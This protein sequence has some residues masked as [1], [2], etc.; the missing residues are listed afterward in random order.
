MRWV[1][2]TPGITLKSYTF[3][4]LL[5]LSK[6]NGKKKKKLINAN[7]LIKISFIIP[8]LWHFILISKP[9]KI[10]MFLS[11]SSNTLPPPQPGHYHVFFCPKIVRSNILRVQPIYP[12][13]KFFLSHSWGQTSCWE[14]RTK[15]K[16][17]QHPQ[18]KTIKKNPDQKMT[19]RT[20]TKPRKNNAFLYSSL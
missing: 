13:T 20:S 18:N 8:N 19:P 12:H 6:S 16:I 17:Y 14:K 3:S 1:Q 7:I 4:K 5:D 10:Y 2:V 9:K 15:A 11:L